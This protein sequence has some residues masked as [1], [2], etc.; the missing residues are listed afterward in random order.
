[1]NFWGLKMEED[2]GKMNE[3]TMNDFEKEL[4]KLLNRGS[5]ENDSDTPDFILAT[6]LTECLEAFNRA[7]KLRTWWYRPQDQI[8]EPIPKK[9]I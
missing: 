9:R 1:M 5:M 6:Y 7:T 2:K 8:N 3:R 4:A